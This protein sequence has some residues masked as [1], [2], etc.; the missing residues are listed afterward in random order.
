MEWEFL[1]VSR[2]GSITSICR[3][4]CV[5]LNA[6]L[7]L[8]KVRSMEYAISWM[9]KEKKVTKSCPV[10]NFQSVDVLIVPQ[11]LIYTVRPTLCRVSHSGSG[12]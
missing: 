7:S 2:L 3:C 9:Q 11:R 4:V 10:I 6:T 1:I 8:T 5:L 12:E